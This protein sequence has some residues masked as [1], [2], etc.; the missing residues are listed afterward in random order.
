[1][2]WLVQL[3]PAALFAVLAWWAAGANPPTLPFGVRVPPDRAGHPVIE[4]ARRGYRWWVAIAGSV[5]LLGGAAAVYAWPRPWTPLL[6]MLAVIAVTVPA[7]ARARAAILLVKRDEHWYRGLT[8]AGAGEAPQRVAV[9]HF[10][11]LWTLP[12]V[13]VLAASVVAGVRWYPHMP[14]QLAMHANAEGV[15]DRYAAK[16]FVSAFA[17]VFIE[18][19]VTALIIITLVISFRA[20]ADLDPGAPEASAQRHRA[21]LQAVAKGLLILAACTNVALLLASWATWSGAPLR[22]LAVLLPVLA[23]LAALLGAVMVATRRT[24]GPIPVE[25]AGVVHRDDDA[26]WKGG[27][28]YL[29]RED[30]ALFVPKRFGIGWTLN[31]AS[32]K[33]FL[34]L[35]GI[36][37]FVTLVVALAA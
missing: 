6:P 5:V 9:G 35:L 20:K 1:V 36:A 10:P 11:W 14:D 2:V 21:V 30:R 17:L 13:I 34:F 7:W 24:R 22:P 12:A 37:A 4:A 28:F 19:G 32:P 31:F 29:N 15:V 27:V 33:A 25:T 18:A 3:V 26:H 23:G 16:S 8:Q